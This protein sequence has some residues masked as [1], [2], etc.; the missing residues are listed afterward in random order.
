MECTSIY[1]AHV[2]FTNDEGLIYS[3]RWHKTSA[4]VSVTIET[5][6]VTV[7]SSDGNQPIEILLFGGIK[8]KIKTTTQIKF[9]RC[10]FLDYIPICLKVLFDYFDIEVFQVFSGFLPVGLG[11]TIQQCFP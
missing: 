6:Y 2:P 5:D 4:T 7:F 1:R 11:G 9:I 10:H 8:M 3:L